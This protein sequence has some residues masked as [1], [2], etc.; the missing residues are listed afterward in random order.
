MRVLVRLC[1]VVL[2]VSC[3]ACGG[4][5]GSTTDRSPSGTGTDDTSIDDE[6][7]ESGSTASGASLS[8]PPAPAQS[9]ATDTNPGATVDVPI[10][11][12]RPSPTDVRVIVNINVGGGQSVPVELDTGS[13]G[14]LIDE[15]AVGPA[16]TTNT[17]QTFTKTFIGQSATGNVG[18]SV[19]QIGGVSTPG[20]I[21][22]GLLP[23]DS[24]DGAENGTRGLLGIA[25]GYGDAEDQGIF[26]PQ[27]Q[28]PA[29]YSAGYTLDV[30]SDGTGTWTLGTPAAGAS[31]ISVPL[32]P[33]Q[34]VADSVTGGQSFAKAVQLCWI[35][36]QQSPACGPTDL[37]TGAPRTAFN[38]TNFANLNSGNGEMATGQ[39]IGLQTSS[40]SPLWSFTTGSTVGQDVVAVEQMGSGS[41]FNSGVGFFFGNLIGLDFTAGRLL[42]TPKPA[43]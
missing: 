12:V 5:S 22:I 11:T 43:G 2:L 27:L 4:A 1:A 30:A 3:A 20:P 24:F 26:S 19:V 32:A 42:I 14:L 35:I 17:G 7:S 23:A 33:V 39:S 41:E 21:T 10:T 25:T 6:V 31:A 28:L 15:S 37:D 9:S 34:G 18:T 13:T 8:G 36:A 40:G 16:V 29:P 38:S